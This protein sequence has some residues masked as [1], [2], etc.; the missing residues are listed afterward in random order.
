MGFHLSASCAAIILHN[1]TPRQSIR[2]GI[3]HISLCFERT[4]PPTTTV[5]S[6]DYDRVFPRLRPCSSHQRSYFSRS[7]LSVIHCCVHKE[8]KIRLLC[9]QWSEEKQRRSR[10][11]TCY[12]ST[13]SICPFSSF[14]LLNYSFYQNVL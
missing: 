8:T 2:Q 7:R 5:F 14:S 6:P 3:A 10:D 12:L 11:A 9:S 13:G 4:F 1:T